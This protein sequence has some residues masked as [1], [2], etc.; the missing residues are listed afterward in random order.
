MH[1]RI[2]L[3]MCVCEI[4]C[5]RKE[6]RK[7]CQFTDRSVGIHRQMTVG[8]SLFSYERMHADWFLLMA[9]YSAFIHACPNMGICSIST[10]AHV[11]LYTFYPCAFVNGFSL[12][13]CVYSRPCCQVV[14]E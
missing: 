14:Q 3:H 8:L 7:C 2:G 12:H 1:V 6:S 9:L 13:L 5:H 4:Y 10:H 11:P